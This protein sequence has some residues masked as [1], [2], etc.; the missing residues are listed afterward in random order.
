MLWLPQI[1]LNGSQPAQ[2]PNAV[3]GGTEAR[4]VVILTGPAIGNA[5]VTLTS[6]N[7]ALLH[8][9][10]SVTVPSGQSSV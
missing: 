2:Q 5:V 7:T 3:P 9:P 4:G 6:G 8:L 10:A 1:K